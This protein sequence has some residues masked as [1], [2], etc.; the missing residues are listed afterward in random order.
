MFPLSIKGGTKAGDCKW[1]G[2][3][4]SQRATIA[5]KELTSRISRHFVELY[6]LSIT[7]TRMGKVGESV[8]F[9]GEDDWIVWTRR[10]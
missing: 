3:G 7:L 4:S 2:S 6:K 5:P 10:I 1:T 9:R 8:T